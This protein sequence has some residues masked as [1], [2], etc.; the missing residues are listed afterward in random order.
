MILIAT[1]L[2][3]IAYIMCVSRA[4]RVLPALLY[5]GCLFELFAVRCTCL[6]IDSDQGLQQ[7]GSTAAAAMVAEQRLAYVGHAQ[8]QH[9]LFVVAGMLPVHPNPGQSMS[10]DTRVQ[11]SMQ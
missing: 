11:C 1:L 9:G 2:L 6:G 4:D 10:R 5:T 3:A 8:V 7:C